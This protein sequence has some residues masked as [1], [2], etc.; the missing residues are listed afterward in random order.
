MFYQP[1]CI[2]PNLPTDEVADSPAGKARPARRRSTAV[3]PGGDAALVARF[4][5]NLARTAMMRT[6]SVCQARCLCCEGLFGK[7]SGR[8]GGG[9]VSTGRLRCRHGKPLGPPCLPARWSN[10][11]CPSCSAACPQFAFVRECKLISPPQVMMDE[12]P[13]LQTDCPGG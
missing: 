12:F 9:W 11:L 8:K 10:A 6:S 5:S 1:H 7:Q 3:R 4:L 13:Q 2:T